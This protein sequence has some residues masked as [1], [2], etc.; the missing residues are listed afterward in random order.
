MLHPENLVWLAWIAGSFLSGSL[1]FSQWIP[2]LVCHTDIRAQSDDANPGA[3]NVFAHC[4]P[5]WGTVCLCLDLAKG[6]V[7]VF[8]CS[9]YMPT[10]S[11]WFGLVLAAP[12][13]GHGL[14]PLAGFRGGKCIATSFGAL[15]GLL[16]HS[17]IVFLLATLYVLFST[18]MPIHPNSHRSI[19]TFGLFGAGALVHLLHHSQYAL[20]VGCCLIAA[21]V[22]WRHVKQDKEM[23]AHAAQTA[24]IHA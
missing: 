21:T 9:H 19:L 24:H 4:G 6:F 17:G 11:L 16:P 5:V 14:A 3:T 20:A 22:I 10:D 23:A 2:A 13:L 12:V 8:L 7:P 1:M 15:L 18:V